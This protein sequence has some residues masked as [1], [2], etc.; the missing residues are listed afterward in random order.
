M[1]EESR[2]P[3]RVSA[4]PMA[5]ALVLG[6][7]ISAVSTLVHSLHGHAPSAVLAVTTTAVVIAA[8]VPLSRHRITLPMAVLTL[9]AGETLLHAWFAWF[10]MPASGEPM[11]TTAALH[12][13]GVLTAHL[14]PRDFTVL[15][16][17][18][19]MLVGHVTAALVLA[20]IL[21]HAESGFGAAGRLL[22]ALVRRLPSMPRLAP[23]PRQVTTF[24]ALPAIVPATITHDVR[25]RGPPAIRL[26]RVHLSSCAA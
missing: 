26:D 22:G 23:R 3:A 25:R 5:R 4:L 7:L 9:L 16:P 11:T 19:G 20:W 13:G 6:L 8:C 10:S 2:L 18:P 21:V 1:A 12:H 24:P 17:T 14:A 15:V